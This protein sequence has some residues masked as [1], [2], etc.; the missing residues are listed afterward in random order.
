MVQQV[1]RNTPVKLGVLGRAEECS[2]EQ[3]SSAEQVALG[4]ARLA[5]R[6]QLVARSRHVRDDG[7]C[8]SGRGV[9]ERDPDRY[10]CC[11]PACLH[12]V[13][14]PGSRRVSGQGR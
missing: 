2:L 1:T 9:A 14:L 8:A 10:G 12:P 4:F 11:E 6:A 13:R 7:L 5:L 3:G